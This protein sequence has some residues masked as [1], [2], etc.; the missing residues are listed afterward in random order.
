MG[1]GRIAADVKRRQQLFQRWKVKKGRL[2]ELA[3]KKKM[4]FTCFLREIIRSKQFSSKSL[5][6]SWLPGVEKQLQSLELKEGSIFN[7]QICFQAEEWEI[8]EH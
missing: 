5:I 6:K 1:E 7:L 3:E 2:S 4:K 8:F